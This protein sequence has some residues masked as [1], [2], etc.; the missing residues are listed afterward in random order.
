MI[1]NANK[2]TYLHTFVILSDE[3]TAIIMMETP[4]NSSLNQSIQ[5]C[6]YFSF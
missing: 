3:E 4:L 1:L 6:M 2:G 5:Q